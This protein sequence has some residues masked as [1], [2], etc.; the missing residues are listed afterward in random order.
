MVVED[1]GGEGMRRNEWVNEEET[2][3][4]RRVGREKMEERRREREEMMIMEEKDES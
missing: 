3:V 1:E 2:D 4:L